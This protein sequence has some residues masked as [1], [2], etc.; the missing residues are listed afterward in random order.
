MKRER[1]GGVE[2]VLS[3]W[4]LVGMLERRRQRRECRERRMSPAKWGGKT[5]RKEENGRICV[6]W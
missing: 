2:L 4:L 1:P 5:E 6:M 3:Y